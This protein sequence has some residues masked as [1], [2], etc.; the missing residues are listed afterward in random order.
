MKKE[1]FKNWTLIRLEKVFSLWKIWEKA[2]C[3]HNLRFHI[4]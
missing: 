1:T 3:Q 2:L 4:I